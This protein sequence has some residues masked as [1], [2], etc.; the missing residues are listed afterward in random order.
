MEKLPPLDP[1]RAPPIRKKRIGLIFK[2]P[3]ETAAQYTSNAKGRQNQQNAC[4]LATR[5]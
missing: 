1:L 4:E 2:Q 3:R 5:T